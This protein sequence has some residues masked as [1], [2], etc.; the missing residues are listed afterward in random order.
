MR[1][2]Y[3]IFSNAKPFGA[4]WIEGDRARLREYTELAARYAAY[5]RLALSAAVNS[6]RLGADSPLAFVTNDVLRLVVDRL[7]V[8]ALRLAVEA[9][10]SG[11]GWRRSRQAGTAI[12]RFREQGWAWAATAVMR[13]EGDFSLGSSSSSGTPGSRPS[14][15]GRK[16][17]GR[18]P[19]SSKRRAN[20]S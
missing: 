11:P 7:S 15:R 8:E 17:R 13:T 6:D 10:A 19:L 18:K 5:R 12:V 20:R 2:I 1:S 9:L 4:K 16:A 14:P 3:L